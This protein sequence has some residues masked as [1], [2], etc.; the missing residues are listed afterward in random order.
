MEV[1]AFFVHPD[2]PYRRWVGNRVMSEE[3]SFREGYKSYARVVW[4]VDSL[5][6]N[7]KCNRTAP[8]FGVTGDERNPVC[9][10]GSINCDR[11]RKS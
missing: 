3:N 1:S 4:K 9:F 7:M 5:E 6:K 11:R 8:V 10:G 2:S